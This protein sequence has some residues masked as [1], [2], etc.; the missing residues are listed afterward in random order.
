[1]LQNPESTM[2]LSPERQNESIQLLASTV[3][4]KLVYDIKRAKYY[5][6]M[7]DSTPDAAHQE[8]TLETMRYVDIKFEGKT[9][10]VKDSF[11]GYIQTHK[12]DTA[13][14]ADIILQ[15]LEKNKLSFEDCRS[16]CYDHT[17]STLGWERMKTA[18]VVSVKSDSE[19]CYSARVEVVK[20]IHDQLEHMVELLE[21]IADDQ[22]ENSD[23][24]SE[25]VQLLHWILTIAFLVL[26]WFWNTVLA[27]TDRVQKRLQGHTMNSIMLLKI[28]RLYKS[29]S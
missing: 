10:L 14:I 23:S 28:F 9:V 8:Q 5:G 11:L 13:S 16:Q 12:K 18:L 19:T 7:F 21:N 4:E 27:R 1:M 3:R 2:Y 29:M 22:D 25:A 20:L 6:I 17:S 15:Q 26:L 24:R